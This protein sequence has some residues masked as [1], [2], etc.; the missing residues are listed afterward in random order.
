MIG[1]TRY[2]S[3]FKP[4]FG[5]ADDSNKI[6]A[7]FA[8][9]QLGLVVLYGRLF[10]V[11]SDSVHGANQMKVIFQFIFETYFTEPIESFSS[12]KQLY[13]SCLHA[14]THG[15]TAHMPCVD[16]C[17]CNNL[18]AFLWINSRSPTGSSTPVSGYGSP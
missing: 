5:S 7:S 4:F 15:A 2:R 8:T 12:S 11:K 17:P 6:F 3:G 18:F 14:C 10:D 1:R 16:P 9:R 13:L